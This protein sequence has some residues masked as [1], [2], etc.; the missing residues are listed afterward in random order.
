MPRQ[1][2]KE[3]IT[4]PNMLKVKAGGK[5]GF[6][7]EAVRRAEAALD[8]LSSEFDDWLEQEIRLLETARDEARRDGLGG[9]AGETLYLKAHDL[10]GLGVTYGYPIVSR[11]GDSLSRMLENPKH[12][13]AAPFAL[14]DA[15]VKA[16]RAAVRDGVK[17][18]GDP[19]SEALAGELEAHVARIYPSKRTA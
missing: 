6:N 7:A 2:P 19:V 18:G 14:A 5:L 13:E 16:I 9:K 11:L 15:H 1:K 17:N 8:N 3:I 10:K 12:R 4:P